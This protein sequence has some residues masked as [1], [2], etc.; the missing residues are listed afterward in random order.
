MVHLDPRDSTYNKMSNMNKLLDTY[1][2][3][4]KEDEHHETSQL[5]KI[6]IGKK[7]YIYFT[8]AFSKFNFF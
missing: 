1:N 6:R 7:D 2:E 5:V 8:F 4:G 3:Q